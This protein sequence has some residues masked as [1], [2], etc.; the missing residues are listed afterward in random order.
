MLD[1]TRGHC[2]FKVTRQE[3]RLRLQSGLS[4]LSGS[5]SSSGSSGSSGTLWHT[6]TMVHT[7]F[8]SL[9]T[10]PHHK[11]TKHTNRG[12]DGMS[13]SR[14]TERGQKKGCYVLCRDDQSYCPQGIA[15]C[16]ILTFFALSAF[17]VR[18]A[19]LQ[20]FLSCLSYLHYTLHNYKE[21]DA[22]PHRSYQ[23]I[24]KNN[25]KGPNLHIGTM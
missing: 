13:S 17:I 8:Q 5:S 10:A 18:S 6:G 2:R 15:S 25:K 14:P 9:D 21:D 22:N 1:D 20:D 3:I 16:S 7:K 23:S 4:G 11:Q 19:L 12:M 24:I